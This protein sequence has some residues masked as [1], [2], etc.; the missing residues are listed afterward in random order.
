MLLC[1]SWRPNQVD[2]YKKKRG[3]LQ[4][5]TASYYKIVYIL[6]WNNNE[7]E[8]DGVLFVAN[9]AVLVL[10][11]CIYFQILPWCH[12]ISYKSPI[13]I[14]RNVL[15]SLVESRTRVCIEKIY[16]HR[17]SRSFRIDIILLCRFSS[18]DPCSFILL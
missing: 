13:I 14:E 4:A 11:K 3:L 5:I 10:N 6:V 17:C 9:L 12:L 8:S 18:G 7:I 2:Y 15:S 1:K 16:L